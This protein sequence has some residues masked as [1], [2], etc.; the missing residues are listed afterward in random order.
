M[1]CGEDF[2]HHRRSCQFSPG[3]VRF[4]SLVDLILMNVGTDILNIL[5]SRI[6][7]CKFV[8]ST[9]ACLQVAH[10]IDYVIGN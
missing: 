10:R 7:S 5:D 3:Q 6:T 9:L 4:T 2:E 8:H 1:G